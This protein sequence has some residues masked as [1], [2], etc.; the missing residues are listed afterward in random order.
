MANVKKAVRKVKK[1]AKA[2]AKHLAPFAPLWL[3]ELMAGKPKK[4]AKTGTARLG[5]LHPVAQAALTG[6]AGLTG[7]GRGARIIPPGALGPMAGRASFKKD[8]GARRLPPGYTGAME[9]LA[10]LK[11]KKKLAS[12]GTRGLPEQQ[13]ARRRKVAQKAKTRTRKSY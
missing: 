13:E 12:K 11:P 10:S 3:G 9:G 5:R 8:R 7:K 4:A 6:I 2:T 1:A